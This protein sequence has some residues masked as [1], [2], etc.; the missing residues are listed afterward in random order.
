MEKINKQT[1]LAVILGFLVCDLL[2][3]W[4]WGFSLIPQLWFWIAGISLSICYGYITQEL[5]NEADTERK[6][7][8]KKSRKK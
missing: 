5:V 2:G 4:A 3:I 8:T 1:T 6:V 7:V